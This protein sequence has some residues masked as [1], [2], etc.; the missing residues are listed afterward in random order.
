LNSCRDDQKYANS[1]VE[2]C[3]L[4][5]SGGPYGENIA[6]GGPMLTLSELIICGLLLQI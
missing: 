4:E 2:N 1:R 5:H 3:E 6:E